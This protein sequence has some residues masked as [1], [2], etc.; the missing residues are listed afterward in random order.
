MESPL[1]RPRG[2]TRDEAFRGRAGFILMKGYVGPNHNFKNQ[3][4][5]VVQLEKLEARSFRF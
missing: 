3:A 5:L 2:A 4:G 1:R